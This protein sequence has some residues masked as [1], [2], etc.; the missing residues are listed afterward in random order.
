MARM[1]RVPANPV[2]AVISRSLSFAYTVAVE[3]PLAPVFTPPDVCMVTPVVS[4]ASPVRT[5]QVPGRFLSRTC[6]LATLRLE[7]AYSSRELA[8]R[9]IWRLCSA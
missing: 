8:Y 3:R 7:L 6:E 1:A 2:Y 9:P 5:A 4:P